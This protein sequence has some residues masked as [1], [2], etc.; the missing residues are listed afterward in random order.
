MRRAGKRFL[1]WRAKFGEEPNCFSSSTTAWPSGN[2][3]NKGTP[4]SSKTLTSFSVSWLFSSNSSFKAETWSTRYFLAVESS[5]LLHFSRNKL[6]M[7]GHT[8]AELSWF[9]V[10]NS[11]I[12][13][14]WQEGI[15][16]NGANILQRRQSGG[17]SS[18]EELLFRKY[19]SP[20]W[21]M[22][23]DIL[24]ARFIAVT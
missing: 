18:W 10:V 21:T 4:F 12:K 16:L 23:D 3:R 5:A 11:L 20:L 13:W 8:N 9:W 6:P 2:L 22:S 24:Q 14:A 7:V 1:T 15:L 17:F 19:S